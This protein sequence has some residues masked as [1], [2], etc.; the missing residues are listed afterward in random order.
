[1]LALFREFRLSGKRNLPGRF[2][3]L[4]EILQEYRIPQSDECKNWLHQEIA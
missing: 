4:T 1:M 2:V 3:Y